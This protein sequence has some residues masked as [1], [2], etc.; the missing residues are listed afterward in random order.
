MRKK[1][2]TL[3]ELLAVIVILGIIL[4]MVVVSVMH[5]SNN[6]REE[7]YENIVSLIEKNTDL[8]I[9][10]DSEMYSAVNSKLSTIHSECKIEYERLEDAGLMDDGTVNPK[11]DNPINKESYIK[12]KLTEEYDFEYT[13]IDKDIVQGN[14]SIDLCL[15]TN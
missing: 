8:F 15:S 14:E 3:I 7:D 6:R 5:F 2:F 13:F 4:G 12:V 11:T 9:N 1:G 10:S